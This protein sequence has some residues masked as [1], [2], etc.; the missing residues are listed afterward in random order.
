MTDKEIIIGGVVVSECE[1]LANYEN[2]LFV[3]HK[4]GK[5]CNINKNCY[6]KQ[7]KRLEQENAELK[8]YKDVN[9]D[10]K[11]AWEELKAENEQLKT[12]N[13]RFE[14][15]QT[16]MCEQNKEF[17][18]NNLNLSKENA[19]IIED[20]SKLF[21]KAIET[22]KENVALQDTLF[23][24]RQILSKIK[25]IAEKLKSPHCTDCTQVLNKKGKCTGE[26]M[27]DYKKIILDLITKA[28]EE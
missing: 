23:S 24:Y 8:A 22:R 11:T 15:K 17:I 9:E 21:D 14:S 26:C 25:A 5:K 7:L 18:E 2:V 13:F 4:T 19:R 6:Y 27:Y 1:E 20:N 28:E 3:C 10:F 12:I 16:A